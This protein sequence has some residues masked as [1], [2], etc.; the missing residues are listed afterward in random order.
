MRIDNKSEGVLTDLIHW[1][2]NELLSKEAMKKDPYPLFAIDEVTVE[3]TF[4]LIGEVDGGF[5]IKLVKAGSKVGE[6]RTQKA[7][8]K[9]KPIVPYTKI[10]P[11]LGEKHAELTE[12]VI[13]DSVRVILKGKPP[14]DQ[15]SI[16]KREP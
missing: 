16:A 6:N 13:D 14:E 15:D 7:I 11:E 1:V 5:D 3:I 4:E 8:V 9:M 12:K 2:K 10:V